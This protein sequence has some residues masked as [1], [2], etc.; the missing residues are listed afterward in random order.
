[1][2]SY[3]ANMQS[4]FRSGFLVFSACNEENTLY[5]YNTCDPFSILHIVE[6]V[7]CLGLLFLS[8]SDIS[9]LP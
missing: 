5:T 9:I 7:L 4:D 2:S 6:I 3:V 8:Q 1:M